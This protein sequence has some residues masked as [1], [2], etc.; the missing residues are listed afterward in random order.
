MADGDHAAC[1]GQLL[2]PVGV[3]PQPA[4]QLDVLAPMGVHGQVLDRGQ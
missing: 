3:A 2:E 4:E 1:L